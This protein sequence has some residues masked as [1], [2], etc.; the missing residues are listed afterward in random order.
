MIAIFLFIQ[1]P[2]RRGEM[3][4]QSVDDF[5]PFTS[6]RYCFSRLFSLHICVYKTSLRI[7]DYLEYK[8]LT[9]YLLY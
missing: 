9:F 4:R 3:F 7:A 6:S 8:F 1:D 5:G 2:P